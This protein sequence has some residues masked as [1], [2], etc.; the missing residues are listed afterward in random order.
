MTGVQT[1]AL[2]ISSGV[3]ALNNS[4][5]GNFTNIT[6]LSTLG[7]GN[8]FLGT[9]AVRGGRFTGSSLAPGSGGKYRLGGGGCYVY[10]TYGQSPGGNPPGNYPLQ[11]QNG[12]LNGANSV[13]IGENK[14]DGGG[15]V[16]LA[17]NNTFSGDLDVQGLSALSYTYTYMGPRTSL[18]AKALPSGQN[19]LGNANGTL[20]LHNS[21]LWIVPNLANNGV[22]KGTLSFEGRSRIVV[23]DSNGGIA[24]TLTLTNVNR[25]NRGVL[26][27]GNYR[28][29]TFGATSRVLVTGTAPAVNNGIVE[30]SIL[31]W[32]NCGNY[33]P[34]NGG[35][36]DFAA[37]SAGNG[38]TNFLAYV[39][40]ASDNTQICSASGAYAGTYN[41][42]LLSKTTI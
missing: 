24:T 17:G 4:A 36:L 21:E 27:V 9:L 31:A 12:V 22:A 10:N 35:S 1:C 40:P 38:F 25:L 16:Y 6:D 8:M 28:N 3:L 18:E 34:Q 19:S 37:F 42:S 2:P 7:N 33:S 15:A 39:A 20:N 5:S 13:Q 23:D 32:Q 26:L 30:P 41:V 14:A 29:T 11:I